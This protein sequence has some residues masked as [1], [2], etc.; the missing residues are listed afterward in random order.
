ML[1]D[2]DVTTHH[3]HGD[4]LGITHGGHAA[5]GRRVAHLLG[6]IVAGNRR[7]DY[8]G[9][10]QHIRG[11]PA[12]AVQFPAHVVLGSAVGGQL[13]GGSGRQQDGRLAGVHDAE[14]GDR[15]AHHTG[16]L[17]EAAG[18]VHRH[19]PHTRGAVVRQDHAH[20]LAGAAVRAAQKALHLRHGGRHDRQ[21]V[22]PLVL[23]KKPVYLVE[24]ALEYDIPRLRLWFDRGGR[25]QAC[26]C[27]NRPSRR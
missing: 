11:E 6:P 22:A 27:L 12:P 3:H 10:L 25:R 26:N 9:T 4:V 15:A 14:V 5:R 1:S 16:D 7:V 24:F 21:A 2:G 8:P 17:R 13:A 23:V 19:A 18:D 20:H